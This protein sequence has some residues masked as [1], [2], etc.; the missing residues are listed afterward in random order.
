M[1]IFTWI[2][3][4]GSLIIAHFRF[5]GHED[6]IMP[7]YK[8]SCMEISIVYRIA[9]EPLALDRFEYSS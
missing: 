2:Y 5:P 1:E 9:Y 3:D 7:Y 8:Q 4:V 6:V